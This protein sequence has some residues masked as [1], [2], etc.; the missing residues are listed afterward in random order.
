[1]LRKIIPFVVGLG[2][3]A[4]VP[5]A[6]QTTLTVSTWVPPQHQI[7]TIILPEWFALVEKATEGRVKFRVLPKTAGS[8]AGQIDAIRDGL[9]D[10]GYTA[11]AYI[12]GRFTLQE[13]AEL[14]L[15]GETPVESGVAYWRIFK[16]HL[17]KF[18]E[19]KGVVV[20]SLMVSEGR[21]HNT[22][23]DV[24]S[25]DDM[26]GL[27]VRTPGGATIEIAKLLGMVPVQK[28]IS[29]I[30]E[31]LSTG[32][33]D[34]AMMPMETV[35]SFKLLDKLTHT[36]V[37]PGGLYN[38][39][40]SLFINPEKFASLSPKDQDA[41]RKVSGETFARIWGR[42]TTAGGEKAEEAAIAQGNKVVR[43][44]AEL[45]KA[46]RAAL[47]PLEQ[48]WIADAKAKGLANAAEV[49]EELR[50]EA[51]KVKQGK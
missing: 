7:N 48:K 13:M 31:L 11:H 21:L 35:Q 12:P 46:G 5:A 29:E 30:Y 16:K 15:L 2:L 47:Q 6:A 22:S 1:M 32:V 42:T 28:P 33:V 37:L 34:A 41:I 50:A 39:S 20:L 44:D 23:R 49:L 27:K 43:A 8:T 26:K 24:K 25:L 38:S 9:A 51:E 45:T 4:A 17:E 18:D 19:H 10:V 36:L 40:Y 3:M 14:P